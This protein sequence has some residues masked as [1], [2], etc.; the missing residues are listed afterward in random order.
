MHVIGIPAAFSRIAR[1]P[2]QDLS[3]KAQERLRWLNCWQALRQQGLP[4]G[5]ASQVLSL[6]RS[7]LYR[8]QRQL[9]EHGLKGLEDKSRRPKRLR[10]PMW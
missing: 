10:Q 9:K 2:P 4:S 3:L 8:W 5:K 6:P 1:H 7:T